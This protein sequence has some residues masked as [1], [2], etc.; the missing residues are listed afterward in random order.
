MK[1]IQVKSYV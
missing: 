1:I